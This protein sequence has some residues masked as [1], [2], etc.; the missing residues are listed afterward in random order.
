MPSTDAVRYAP[1]HP[2]LAALLA[3]WKLSGWAEMMVI[4]PDP[5]I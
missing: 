5:M 2:T 3:A 1:V 4:R